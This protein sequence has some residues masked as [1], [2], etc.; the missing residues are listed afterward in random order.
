MRVDLVPICDLELLQIVENM[1]QQDFDEIF[2]TR[3]NCN[4]LELVHDL[5]AVINRPSSITRVACLDGRP[6]AVIGAV[7]PWPGLWDVWCFGTNDFDKVA[8]SLTKYVRRIF[9]PT[10]LERGLRRAHCRSMVGHDKSHA[11]LRELGA[12]PEDER[13]L[14]NWGRFGEDFVMFVWHRE[15]LLKSY[16]EAG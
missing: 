4:P 8:L 12:E 5:M 2:C 11:W 1:R 14:P 10:M 6:V 15:K 13:S 16:P 9:I 7:E 3:W